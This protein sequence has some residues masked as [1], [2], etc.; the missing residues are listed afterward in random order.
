MTVIDDICYADVQTDSIRVIEVTPV[1][2]QTLHL[3]FSTGEE[4]NFHREKLTGSVFEP[5]QDESV[6]CDII[7]DL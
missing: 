5:L 6:F 2:G 4:S 3:V 1:N 7:C